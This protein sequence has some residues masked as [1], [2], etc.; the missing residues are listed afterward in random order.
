MEIFSGLN[1]GKYGPEKTP[2]LDTSRSVSNENEPKDWLFVKI[3]QCI[4]GSYFSTRILRQLPK[5]EKQDNSNIILQVEKTK[6]MSLL[7]L[8]CFHY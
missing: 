7:L 3:S 8:W 1:T 2:Y 6:K 4:I 5:V